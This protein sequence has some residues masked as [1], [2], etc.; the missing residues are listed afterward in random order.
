MEGAPNPS[1]KKKDKKSELDTT[2]MLLGTFSKNVF[3][4]SRELF[5]KHHNF[6]L[7]YGF[8]CFIVFPI[9]VCR[10]YNQLGPIGKL[11]G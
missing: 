3:K 4:S 7:F 8:E 11:H 1:G 2:M 6:L 9:F 5:K 10:H